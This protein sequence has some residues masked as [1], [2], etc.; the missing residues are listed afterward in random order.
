[1]TCTTGQGWGTRAVQAFLHKQAEHGHPEGFS[2][3]EWVHTGVGQDRR[4]AFECELPSGQPRM[5]SFL[6]AELGIVC[7]KAQLGT[8]QVLFFV[9]IG[10]MDGQAKAAGG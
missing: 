2:A 10:L 8:W 6:W 9:T 7:V 4:G 5:V 3:L 1:M